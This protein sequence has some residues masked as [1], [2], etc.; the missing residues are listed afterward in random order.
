MPE[1]EITVDGLNARQQVIADILWACESKSQINKFIKSLPTK[2]LQVEADGVFQL[3]LMAT[4]EQAY[5]GISGNDQ[6]MDLINK[7]KK[8]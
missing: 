5:N 4:L 2:E 1:I 7:V 6:A 8:G 3:I